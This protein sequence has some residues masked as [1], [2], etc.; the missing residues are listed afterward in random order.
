MSQEGYI[1]YIELSDEWSEKPM[2]EIKKLA[3]IWLARNW[4]EKPTGDDWDDSPAIHN[5]GPPYDLR[6]IDLE[7][8]DHIIILRRDG[9]EE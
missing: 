6:K 2:N 8:G 3:T 4:W 7:V 1:H 9:K 5:A